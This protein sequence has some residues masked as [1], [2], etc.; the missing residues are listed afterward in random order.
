MSVRAKLAGFALVLAA[1]FVAGFGVGAV[2]DG[3][4]VSAPIHQEHTP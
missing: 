2:T 1:V 4:D 3:P